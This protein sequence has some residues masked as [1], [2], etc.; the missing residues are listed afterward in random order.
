MEYPIC[1]SQNGDYILKSQNDIKPRDI[2]DNWIIRSS[3]SL[4]VLSWLAERV[5]QILEDELRACVLGFQG[6]WGDYLP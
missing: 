2:T 6:K 3:Q 4:V 1:A 5:S